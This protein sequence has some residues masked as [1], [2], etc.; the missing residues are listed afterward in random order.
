[1]AYRQE[2][3]LRFPVSWVLYKDASGEGPYDPML[4]GH[5]PG[6][7][8]ASAAVVLEVPLPPT[9]AT[10]DAIWWWYR[11]ELTL[12]GWHLAESNNKAAGNYAQ[13]YRRGQ[14]ERLTIGFDGET[15]PAFIKY[16]GRGAV[17]SVYYEVASCTDP[18][19]MC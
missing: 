18:A 2:V 5:P 10:A 6:N 14:R 11:Q 13:R 19:S 16:D 7:A 1:M 12:R 4:G 8:P 9:D 17:Y 3:G 15:A